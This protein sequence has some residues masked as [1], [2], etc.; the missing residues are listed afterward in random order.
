MP[1]IS[2]PISITRQLKYKPNTPSYFTAHFTTLVFD[3]PIINENSN[4]SLQDA[5]AKYFR[6]DTS[7]QIW[8]V[9]KVHLSF[10]QN[11]KSFW[12]GW[13]KRKTIGFRLNLEEQ[14]EDVE[15]IAA[16]LPVHTQGNAPMAGPTYNS[17]S[18]NLR[19]ISTS[20]NCRSKFHYML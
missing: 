13:G 11:R 20:S 16:F 19:S 7:L 18:F 9:L 12:I 14:S 6:L 1:H 10:V 15:G 2:R 5:E 4:R 17:V 8:I 3:W